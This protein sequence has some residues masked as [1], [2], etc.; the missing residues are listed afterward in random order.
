MDLIFHREIPGMELMFS[1]KASG[2]TFSA[3]SI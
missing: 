3:Y 1:T 2:T